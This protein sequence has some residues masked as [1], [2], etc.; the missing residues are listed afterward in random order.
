MVRII[1]LER[2]EI[3]SALEL[4]SLDLLTFLRDSGLECCDL[5][6]HGSEPS[7]EI[8]LPPLHTEELLQEQSLMEGSGASDVM[9]E[10]LPEEQNITGGCCRS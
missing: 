6:I 1:I 2:W 5:I 9:W 7:S 8:R 3:R 4:Q 10:I